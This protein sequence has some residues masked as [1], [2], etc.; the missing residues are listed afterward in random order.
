MDP[1]DRIPD[2]PLGFIRRCVEKRQVLWTYHVNMRLDERAITRP[3]VLNSVATYEIIE[4]YPGK[5]HLPS[6]L[7]YARQG[8]NALH[9]VFAL[10][11]KTDNGRVVTA[12]RP[13]LDPWETDMRTRRKS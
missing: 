10:D 3:M 1:G 12:Y 4:S 2:N 5:R 9:I 11:V 13:N 6:Y 8:N 7:V